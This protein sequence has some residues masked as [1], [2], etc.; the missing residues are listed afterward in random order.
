MIVSN[1]GTRRPAQPARKPAQTSSSP[2]P[3][4]GRQPGRSVRGRL[5]L[6]YLPAPVG[7]AEAALKSTRP[8]DGRIA[9]DAAKAEDLHVDTLTDRSRPVLAWLDFLAIEACSDSLA[10]APANRRPPPDALGNEARS[11][12]RAAGL[13]PRA[14]SRQRA[15]TKHDPY[16]AKWANALFASAM[17]WTFSRRVIAAPSRLNAATNS[18]A[19]LIAIG[20]PFFSRAAIRSQRIESVC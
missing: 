5:L 2:A 15:A 17:R 12:A 9:S 19:S 14:A 8:G 13:E 11:R 1:R 18:S 6:E 16:Q 10:A 3:S 20:R 4:N 7:I